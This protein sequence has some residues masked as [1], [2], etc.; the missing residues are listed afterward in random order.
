MKSK[1]LWWQQSPGAFTVF[2]GIYPTKHL[3]PAC[4]ASI[5][6]ST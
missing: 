5:P 1:G 4:H 6:H 3:L 2:Q